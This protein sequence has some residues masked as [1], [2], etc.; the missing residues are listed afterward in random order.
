MGSK[1]GALQRGGN[2]T[3]ATFEETGR[4]EKKHGF[5]HRRKRKG[6]IED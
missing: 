4:E 2:E 1:A 5:P 3:R 6:K